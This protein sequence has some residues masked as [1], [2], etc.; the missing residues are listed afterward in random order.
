MSS[1]QKM[2]WLTPISFSHDSK[3]VHTEAMD[4]PE[5]VPC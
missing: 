3:D 5:L 4:P 2:G 1:A